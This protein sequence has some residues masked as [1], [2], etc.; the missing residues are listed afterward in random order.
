MVEGFPS[1]CASLI[2]VSARH[3]SRSV[4]NFVPQDIMATSAMA[5]ETKANKCEFSFNDKPL[6]SETIPV[7]VNN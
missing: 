6:S 4:S 2:A 5:I 3:K 7:K 1:E